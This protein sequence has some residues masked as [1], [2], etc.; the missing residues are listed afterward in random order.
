M[1]KII[2]YENGNKILIVG[3]ADNV[4]LLCEYV[5]ILYN[6]PY[7]QCDFSYSVYQS[8]RHVCGMVIN[9]KR[10]HFVHNVF[11][12]P[13]AKRQYKSMST[14]NFQSAMEHIDR[15]VKRL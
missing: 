13:L 10:Y 1:D 8:D 12:H 7:P 4:D 6:I 11:K 9:S 2:I 3:S 14:E 5:H 15:L